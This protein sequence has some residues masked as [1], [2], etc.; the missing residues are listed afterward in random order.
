MCVFMGFP[1][2]TFFPVGCSKKFL[3]K[4]AAL[5][6]FLIQGDGFV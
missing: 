1:H 6:E 2:K 3:L 4:N 5:V